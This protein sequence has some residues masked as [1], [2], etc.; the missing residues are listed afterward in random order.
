MA[1]K[2]PSFKK[3]TSILGDVAKGPY[4]GL[5][6]LDEKS[7]YA[8]SFALKEVG[9]AFTYSKRKGLE[10]AEREV[11]NQERAQARFEAERRTQRATETRRR[12]LVNSRRRQRQRLQS[13]YAAGGGMAEPSMISGQTGQRTTVGG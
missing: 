12:S 13:S 3:I 7:G 10:A 4:A 2:L 6:Y 5:E 8:G 11:R 9:S 1:I